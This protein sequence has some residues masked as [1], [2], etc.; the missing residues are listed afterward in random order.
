M[1]QKTPLTTPLRRITVIDALRGFALL[2]VILVHMNQHYGIFSFMPGGAGASPLAAFDESVRWLNTNVL[3]GRFINIFAFLFGLSFFIQIDRARQKGIDFHKRFIWRMAILFVIGFIGNCFYSG[4]ILAI[5]AVFGVV[6]VF[7]SRFRNWVLVTVA[8]LVLCGAPRMIK[9]AYAKLTQTEQPA[10]GAQPAPRN[11]RAARPPVEMQEPSFAN[12]VKNNL[13]RGLE[14]KLN[15]QFGTFG[16][17]YLT[18]ALFVMGLLVGRS[19]FFETVDTRMRRNVILFACFTAGAILVHF[20]VGKLSVPDMR[21]YMFMRPASGMPPAVLLVAALNDIYSVLYSG[22]L[23][24]GFILCFHLRGIGRV[25]NLLSPYGRMGLTNYE[26]Q[27]II[28]CLVF[29]PWALG[30]IFGAWCATELFLLGL[31]IYVVQAAVS[32][33]WLKVFVYGPFEWAWR[34]ATYL[35]VQPLRKKK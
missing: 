12:T 30:T 8:A 15:Y 1:E 4:D 10:P 17:G 16:R 13:T 21:F 24:M 9:V 27:G 7:L 3:M 23:A 6:L 5:Y 32:A 2:G 25:L 18:F 31:L 11:Q 14:G 20:I 34:S 28:G 35:R 29:S 33:G 19:R 26:M 22:A